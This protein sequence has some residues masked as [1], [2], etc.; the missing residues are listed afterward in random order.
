M[1]TAVFGY[2]SEGIELVYL[3]AALALFS[4]CNDLASAYAVIADAFCFFASVECG[5]IHSIRVKV[6]RCVAVKY[7]FAFSFAEFALHGK[8]CH[9]PLSRFCKR[10]V[11]GHSVLLG[12]RHLPYKSLCRRYRAHRVR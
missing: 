7:Y 1:L 10:A 2:R 12:I 3:V 4:V 8:I 5:Y 6:G 11:K 9:V